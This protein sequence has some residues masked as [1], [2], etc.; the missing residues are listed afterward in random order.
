V[1][2]G[3]LVDIGRK[4]V[5]DHVQRTARD[6]LVRAALKH[7]LT[8]PLFG[9]AMKIGAAGAAAAAGLAEDQGAAAPVIAGAWPTRDARA[10]SAAARRLRAA[11]DVAQ[12]QQGHRACARCARHRN[13]AS[14]RRRLLWRDPLSPERSRRAASPT[15]A[16][17]STPGGHTSSTPSEEGLL[18]IIVNASGCGTQVKEYGHLLALDK[19]YAG[20]ARRISELAKDPAE[21]LAGHADALQ[22][23]AA[24]CDRRARG[25]S[26]AVHA[27]ARPE[28]PRRGRA[29][30]TS[31]GA[32]VM[33]VGESH[34]CCGSAGTYSVL[35][36]DL[37]Y[38]L[39]DR[40]LGHLQAPPTC[41]PVG[42]HRLHHASGERHRHP[43][44]ALDRVARRA[45]CAPASHAA[46]AR[47]AAGVPDDR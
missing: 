10:Q 26:L 30:L 36:P 41:D 42:Q 17:T 32:E 25:L 24:D 12:H 15:P 45:A 9:P 38:E 13:A 31:L 21:L 2:Y 16:A 37:A 33:P 8:S 23:T 43:R 19:H 44:H 29:V 14:G 1:Q 4:V 22:G 34:F 35:Q 39:R 46:G 11:G 47:H 27:A 28:D 7:G 18:A 6:R 5:D 3:R 20:K 40:K